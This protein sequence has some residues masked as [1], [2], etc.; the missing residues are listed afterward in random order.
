MFLSSNSSNSASYS[1]VLTLKVTCED[2]IEDSSVN[3]LNSIRNI[4]ERSR[5]SIELDLLPL[6]SLDVVHK[7]IP[8][9]TEIVFLS[10]KT[11]NLR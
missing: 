9:N 8:H 11:P 6:V 4:R 2:R 7:I 1:K 5:N 3:S 10:L